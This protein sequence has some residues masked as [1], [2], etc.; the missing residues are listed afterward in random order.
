MIIQRSVAANQKDWQTSPDYSYLERDKDRN[1]TKTYQV[2]M[3]LGSP[4]S[5]LIAV[6]GEPLSLED[7]ERERQRLEQVT[8]QRESESPDKQEER[9][10]KYERDRERDHLMMEQLADAFDFKLLGEQKLEGVDVYVLSAKP[11]PGYQPA[12]M[13]TKALSGMQGKLWIDKKTFQWV[14]VTAEVVHPVT[15]EGF[16]ARI[17]PGTRFELEKMPVADGIWLPKHFSMVSRARILFLFPRKR[18]EDETY[19][20]YQRL[21]TNAG[22]QAAS[23]ES[24]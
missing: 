18:Q 1:G 9:I 8:E 14:K 16:L 2:S 19:F 13:E 23:G 6:N 17:E 7:R 4:Y 15:I 22:F 3:L 10:R 21:P 20:N 11:R 24:K 12:N 5:S